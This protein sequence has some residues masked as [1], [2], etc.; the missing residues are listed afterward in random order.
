MTGFT[1]VAEVEPVQDLCLSLTGFKFCATTCNSVYKQ[2]QH[3]TS[4]DV[5][6]DD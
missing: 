3:V 5:V 6:T 2:T 1:S 4:N